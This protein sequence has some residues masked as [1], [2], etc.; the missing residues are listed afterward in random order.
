M[1]EQKNHIP[2]PIDEAY[3]ALDKL[4]EA[5]GQLSL[6]FVQNHPN[7]YQASMQGLKVIDAA[8][9]EGRYHATS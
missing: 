5:V 7:L 8:V 4:L 6:S 3:K 1:T 9:K 2:L